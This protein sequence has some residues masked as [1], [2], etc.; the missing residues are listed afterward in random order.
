M[1]R[2][3]FSM[4]RLRPL[5]Q[6]DIIKILKDNGFEEARS[7]KHVTFKKVDSGGKV[8]TTWVPHH[9]EVS[10]F[11]VKYI[12]KFDYPSYLSNLSKRTLNK[13]NK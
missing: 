11:V 6:R 13:N 7:G 12:D 2:K 10:I 9:D 4:A 5:P 1:F 3:V 8:W